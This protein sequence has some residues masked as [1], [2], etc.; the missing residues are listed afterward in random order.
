MKLVATDRFR[1]AHARRRAA[2]VLSEEFRTRIDMPRATLLLFVSFL[3]LAAQNASITGTVSDPQQAPIPN[4]LVT[5]TNVDRGIAVRAKTDVQGNY[6]FGFVRPGNYIIQVEHPGFQAF[7]QGPIQ[8]D[9]DQRARVNVELELGE[10]ASTVNV[11]AGAVGVQT[12]SSSL[13][14]VTATR[15]ILEIPLNGRFI[16]DV[17]LLAPGTVVPSTNNRTFLAV[18]SGVGISGI[19]ASG[20]A[21]I[22]P[23]TCWTEST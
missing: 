20:T 12:E 16:L 10:A 23:T 13:G 14:T 19:N 7:R 5:L 21:R 22:Q 18:P 4:V 3:P 9:V 6:E 11:D 2:S 8:F 1:D 17:A 15:K